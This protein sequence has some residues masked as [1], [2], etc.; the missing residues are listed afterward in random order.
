MA[1]DW[2]TG[3]PTS[4][5]RGESGLSWLQVNDS[6]H[7]GMLSPPSNN[8]VSL[9]ESSCGLMYSFSS[10]FAKH[11]TFVWPCDPSLKETCF[12]STSGTMPGGNPGLMVQ[13]VLA[14]SS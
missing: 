7:S 1:K 4:G 3:Y 6:N 5:Q 14:L 12:F 11:S 2:S 10:V 9:K 13:E 8:H